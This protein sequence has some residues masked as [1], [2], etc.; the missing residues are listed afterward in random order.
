MDFDLNPKPLEDVCAAR[1]RATPHGLMSNADKPKPF[2]LTAMEIAP[3]EPSEIATATCSGGNSQPFTFKHFVAA[4]A[5]LHFN[6][7]IGGR[8]YRITDWTSMSGAGELV[9]RKTYQQSLPAPLA[10][11]ETTTFDLF[12]RPQ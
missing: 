7:G 5:I 2:T 1:R 4:F 9:A 10:G 6:E 3:G 11:T 8:T 12:H